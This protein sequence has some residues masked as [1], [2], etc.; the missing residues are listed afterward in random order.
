MMTQKQF[1]THTHS[2]TLSLSLTHTQRH[3]NSRYSHK[4][5][6]FHSFL[7]SYQLR[8]SVHYSAC[9]AGL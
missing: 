4:N 5:A 1:F 6:N 7:H 8:R 3:F 9:T 2:R